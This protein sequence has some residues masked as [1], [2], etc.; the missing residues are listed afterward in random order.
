LRSTF[1]E[2]EEAVR[3]LM[4]GIVTG[5]PVALISKP[6]T[7]KTAMVDE[8]FARMDGRSFGWLMTRYTT[9]DELA[10]PLSLP[11]L[12]QGRFERV[13][14]GRIVGASNVFLDECYKANS[15]TLNAQLSMLNERQFEGLSCPW[16]VWVGAS[17]EYPAGIGDDDGDAGGDSLEALWDRYIIRCELSYMTDSGNL[18]AAAF[19][20]APV[21]TGERVTL[22]DVAHLR[23][24]CATVTVPGDVREAYIRMIT[25]LRS[26]GVAISDRKVVKGAAIIRAAALLRGRM[27]AV[28]SD[29]QQL[30]F[31]LW[32]APQ[33]RSKVAQECARYQSHHVK[34]SAELLRN[35]MD[36]NS[37]L[38]TSTDISQAGAL[39]QQLQEAHKQLG[40]LADDA[41][42]EG[43]EVV[44]EIAAARKKV[45]GWVASGS[46]KV[47]K[48]LGIT[49]R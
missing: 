30:S 6:G 20:D 42:S 10:G 46:T 18:M 22:E 34:A 14:E 1:H 36:L 3:A 35:A 33:S 8:L 23:A 44:A 48:F 47:Q 9:P 5:Y 21:F 4:L 43:E 12:T 11:A 13:T 31:A 45:A 32:D 40:E 25:N 19:G 17:N 16:Q 7:A 26:A 49:S 24:Q 15:A 41:R 37:R 39:L 29:L 38:S 28:V 2:R 27:Q